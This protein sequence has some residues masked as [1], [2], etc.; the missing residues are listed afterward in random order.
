MYCQ[1]NLIPW[2]DELL[3][4]FVDIFLFTFVPSEIFLGLYVDTVLLNGIGT[5]KSLTAAG[6]EVREDDKQEGPSRERMSSLLELS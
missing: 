6:R 3:T 5:D 4:A 1:E 2:I